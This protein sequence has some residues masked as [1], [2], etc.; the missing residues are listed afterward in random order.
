[1]NCGDLYGQSLDCQWV[2]ITGLRYG[3][4]LLELSVNPR[5][6]GAESD[7]GNNNASCR[8]RYQFEYKMFIGW[9]DTLEVG[10]CWL[11]GEATAVS[12]AGGSCYDQVYFFRSLGM[13][14]G[15]S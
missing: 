3:D 13:G 9:E 5:G 11:S 12:I 7:Y 4:Y 6:L 10:D 14:F 1:M 15:M 2:D 8:I